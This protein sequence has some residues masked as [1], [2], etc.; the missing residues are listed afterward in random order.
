MGVLALKLAELAVVP[1]GGTSERGHI[2]YQDHPPP[3]HIKVHRV[4]LQRGGFQVVEGL[5][6]ERH[7]VSFASTLQADW[8]STCGCIRPLVT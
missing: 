8:I 4:A 3:E 5:G 7:L 2:L 6:D 1:G